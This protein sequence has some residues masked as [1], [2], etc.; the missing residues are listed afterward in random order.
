MNVPT[1]I[2]IAAALV[3]SH[4]LPTFAADFQ[5]NITVVQDLTRYDI[6]ADGTFVNDEQMVFKINTDQGVKQRGQIPISYSSS[7]EELEVLEAYTTTQDGKRIEVA[8]DKIL[9]QQSPQSQRAPSFDDVKVKTVVFPA[10]EVGATLTLHIKKTQKKALFPGQFT[11]LDWVDGTQDTLSTEVTVSAPADYPLYADAVEMQGGKVTSE[12]TPAQGTQMWRWTV[13]NRPAHAPELFSVGLVDVSPKVFLT[14]FPGYEALASAY[15]A[16]AQPQM[17]VTPPLQALA[18]KLTQGISDPRE[19]AKAIYNWVSGNIRYVAIFLEFGGVVPHSAQA[20]LD[21]KYGDCKDFTTLLGALL[22]AKGI[23]N[24]PVLVNATDSYALPKVASVSAFNHAITYLPDFHLFVDATAGLAE[25]GTLPQQE[26][27]K[28]ALVTD[29]GSG[30]SRLMMIPIANAERDTVQTKTTASVD[31]HGTV[32]GK[33]DIGSTGW[34]NLAT[35]QMFA[36][37]PPG[38]EK[39]VAEQMLQSTGQAGKGSFQHG[40]PQD[41]N[42]PFGYSTQ[43]ESPEAIPLPGPGA[44]M[45]YKGLG[46]LTSIGWSLMPFGAPKRDFPLPFPNRSQ[47]ETLVINLPQQVPITALPKPVNLVTPFGSY[48]SH[49]TQTQDSITVE[50]HF[51]TN[52]KTPLIAPEDYP[53]VRD[54]A[55]GVMKD[56][57]GQVI[58][59]R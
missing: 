30:Q 28:M 29:D 58:Y 39:Q 32:S 40:K 33:S 10:V 50:R 52:F 37:L 55:L 12:A 18:D 14:S 48:T 5:P 59:G 42:Q 26:M 24:A 56:L 1:R 20:V 51:K 31:G 17:T 27:G 41:L 53:A 4:H 8:S 36:S 11:S 44:T 3:F 25:F 47:S 38:V 46:S 19:Q 15:L 16:R 54:F 45:L 22:T 9:T 49:Y 13:K 34:L 23:K 43:F 2:A 21:A 7:L 35:R 57:R 6:H